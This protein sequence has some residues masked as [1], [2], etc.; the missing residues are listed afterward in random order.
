[1]VR[2][3][4]SYIAEVTAGAA[5]SHNSNPVVLATR[6]RNPSKP[7]NKRVGEDVSNVQGGQ[8]S[9]ASVDKAEADCSNNIVPKEAGS[10]PVG[11]GVAK[12]AGEGGT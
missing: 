1:V 10:T 4:T 11:Q 5:R 9:N 7:I 8:F 2:K 3:L 12:R 6:G